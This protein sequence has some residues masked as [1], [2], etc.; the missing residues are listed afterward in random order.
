MRGELLWPGVLLT[1][2]AWIFEGLAL[3]MSATVFAR[4]GGAWRVAGGTV[5]ATIEIY[6]RCESIVDLDVPNIALA[7]YKAPEN[8]KAAE[9]PMCKAGTAIT[10]F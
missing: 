8:Y 3:V 1:G 6:D 4:V 5:L 2:C 10:R 9:C 7:E